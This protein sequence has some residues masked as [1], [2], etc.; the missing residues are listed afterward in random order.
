MLTLLVIPGT[1]SANACI[2]SEQ[3]S[4]ELR[5]ET[6]PDLKRRRGIVALSLVAS[7][8]MSLIALYQMGIIKHLPE[9]PLPKL[10]ADKVDASS[11]AYEKFAM[12]DAILGLGS[13][14][15]TMSLAA[16]GV[17]NRAKEMPWVPIALAA[18]IAFDVANAAK[19]SIDQWTKHRAF[20]F[21]CL[22]AATA[23]F[24]MAPLAWREAMS[25]VSA[26]RA[27]PASH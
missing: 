11:E 14:A 18:K 25:A 16:I 5:T 20:C 23:T 6:S 21:W 19:L 10:N 27:A 24:A 26:H 8:S 2:M 12:P 15:A 3:L 9:P 1:Q 17:K 13:Y 22:L 7:G 4:R